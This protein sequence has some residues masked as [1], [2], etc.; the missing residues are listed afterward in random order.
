MK[1]CLLL[2]ASAALRLLWP[3]LSLA[4]PEHGGQAHGGGRGNAFGGDERAGFTAARHAR[5]ELPRS[6]LG[7]HWARRPSSRRRRYQMSA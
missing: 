7:A 3:A 2:P 1:G 4:E 5:L 6:D